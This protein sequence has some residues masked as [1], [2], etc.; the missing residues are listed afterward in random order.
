MS[1]PHASSSASGERGRLEQIISEFFVRS[2][3]LILQSRTVQDDQQPL[4]TRTNRWFN[5]EVEESE[6][7]RVLI[8]PWRRSFN[9]GPMVIEVRLKSDALDK[10]SLNAQTLKSEMEEEPSQGTLIERWVMDYERSRDLSEPNSLTAS[11]VKKASHAT[12]TDRTPDVPVI[13]K[14]TVILVRSLYSLL[15]MLPG[16]R[17]YRACKRNQSAEASLSCHI[18]SVDEALM[19]VSKDLGDSENFK[20]YQLAPVS[21][22]DGRLSAYVVY[23]KTNAVAALEASPPPLPRI[24]C[25]YVNSLTGPQWGASRA[26]NSISQQHPVPTSGSRK[27]SWAGTSPHLRSPPSS[28]PQPFSGPDGGSSLPKSLGA[29]PPERHLGFQPS[30]IPTMP[31]RR[32]STSTG[33]PPPPPKSIPTAPPTQIQGFR[34]SSAPSGNFLAAGSTV[35]TVTSLLPLRHNFP[36]RDSA[37]AGASLTPATS[38]PIE[39]PSSGGLTGRSGAAESGSGPLSS[40][41]NLPFAFTPQASSFIGSSSPTTGWSAYSLEANGPLLTTRRPSW[42]PSSSLNINATAV[43]SISPHFSSTS[44]SLVYS[45]P[46]PTSLVP[47]AFT[48]GQAALAPGRPSSQGPYGPLRLTFTVHED[49]HKEHDEE[50]AFEDADALPFALD[51]E[52]SSA[53][54][55]TPS[56]SAPGSLS[57]F[58]GAEAQSLELSRTGQA[59]AAAGALITM[60]QDAPPLRSQLRS[61]HPLVAPAEGGKDVEDSRGSESTSGGVALV[62]GDKSFASVLDE[63]HQ[64]STLKNKL[65]QRSSADRARRDMSSPEGIGGA[66]STCGVKILLALRLELS[67]SAGFGPCLRALG[68]IL[69]DIARGPERPELCGV[70]VAASVSEMRW[71]HSN[72]PVRHDIENCVNIAPG[73]EAR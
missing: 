17:L 37:G 6:D 16:N 19:A 8:E 68:G 29:T 12:L 54:A 42:S 71:V 49:V 69:P 25:D 31:G 28:S 59:D 5:L 32:D 55:P 64:L 24:I 51:G 44:S 70:E 38:A 10:C 66:A 46:A 20:T 7:A 23:R 1:R 21:T 14:R 72:V 15:K 45:P 63:M 2:G 34:P 47:T 4:K 41:P 73:A 26:I 18:L 56:M 3:N 61:Q 11:S 43:C 57:M 9:Y 67:R 60:L 48:S 39:F 40:S 27:N 33:L 62:S 13:Y 35:Q 53:A 36:S 65:L 58:E 52:T 22:T 50:Q 30:S